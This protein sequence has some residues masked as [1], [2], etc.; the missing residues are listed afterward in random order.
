MRGYFSNI[1][2][3]LSSVIP[4][5]KDPEFL[6]YPKDNNFGLKL[7]NRTWMGN[8]Y[9][10]IRTCTELKPRKRLFHVGGKSEFLAKV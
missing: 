3:S 1:T 10:A 7:K 8:I 6:K 9:V 5:N 2:L 4:N